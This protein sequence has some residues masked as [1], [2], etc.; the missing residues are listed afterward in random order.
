[1]AAALLPLLVVI[2]AVLL[3]LFWLRQFIDLMTQSD[4][5]FPG[6]YDKPVWVAVLLLTGAI[7]ALVYVIYKVKQE[8][9]QPEDIEMAPRDYPESCLKCGKTIPPDAAKCPSCGWSYNNN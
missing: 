4:D 6:K 9:K 3:F 8:A 5:S 2:V 7:G 1:M